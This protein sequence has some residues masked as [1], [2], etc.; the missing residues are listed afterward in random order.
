M[1]IAIIAAEIAPLAKAGG[2]ADVIGALPAA[3]KRA[4]A[5]VTLILP[6]Y[7]ALLSQGGTAAEGEPHGLPFGASNVEFVV[8]KAGG[9]DGVMMRLI[10]YP[11]FF[12][13]PGIYGEDGLDYRDNPRR[14]A[15]FGRA[16]ARIA[17][18]LKPDVVHAHDWHAATATIASR[19]EVEVRDRLLDALSIFTIHNL[20]FQ[21]LFDTRDYPLLNLD[22][23]WYSV[24]HLEFYGRVNLMKGAIVMADGVSTVS[25][26]YAHETAHDL[27]LGSGL[28]GV[29]LNKGNRYRGILNGADY[30]EWDPSKDKL[31]GAQYSPQRRNGKKA[32]LYDLRE[33]MRLPHRI[34]T[35][36]IGMVTR[37]TPQKGIDL[38]AQALDE[39]L[40]MDVQ[41]VM[42]ASG[43]HQYEEF[44]NNAQRHYPER[45]RVINRFDNALAHRIQA[46]SDM[47]LMPS[48]YEPCG[49]TQMYALKYGTVP[50][51]RATGGLRDTVVEFEMGSCTGNGF[52]F[53]E[54]ES[55]ALV[56]AVRRAA[57]VFRN[58]GWWVR[59][60]SNCFKADFSW[61]L[62]AQEY[63]RW[64]ER[65]RD[66]RSAA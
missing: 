11:E 3:L 60:M 44:F 64:F 63:L 38:L 66:T 15:F 4:G 49:L 16:A 5:D 26:T 32:C 12:D 14:Y 42:L 2:L 62:A 39:I 21:G 47:F 54:Y 48:R 22:W 28:G 30:K 31:I 23:T 1:K 6:G 50:I 7:R 43:E 65:L 29:L 35:P 55:A 8:R 40:N 41:L 27:E 59:L 58:T 57:S 9:P 18:E 36:V 33:E 56:A 52:T 51:V 34:D 20:A 61:D 13:R 17:A 19:A 53:T 37:M 25:P 10:D 24:E 46:G 45:L